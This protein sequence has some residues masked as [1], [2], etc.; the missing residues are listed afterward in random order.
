MSS[1]TRCGEP[2]QGGLADLGVSALAIAGDDGVAD[3][4]DEAHSEEGARVDGVES[5]SGA[6]LGHAVGEFATGGEIGKDDVA[7]E[8]EEGIADLVAVADLTRNVEFHHVVYLDADSAVRL[9]QR[10][11]YSRWTEAGGMR[12]TIRIDA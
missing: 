6:H 11:F 10:Q 1:P 5:G 4:V 8:V 7:D 9:C 3:L 2:L 12:D